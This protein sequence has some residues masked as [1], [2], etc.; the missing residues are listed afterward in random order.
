M[1]TKA[2]ATTSQRQTAQSDGPGN[3]TTDLK[4]V[5]SVL[6]WLGENIQPD[7]LHVVTGLGFIQSI[8]IHSVIN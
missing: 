7:V 6:Q 8:K 3:T 2:D 1:P 5:A 4:D